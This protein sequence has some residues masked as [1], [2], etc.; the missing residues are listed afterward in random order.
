MVRLTVALR[1]Q[2]K[3]A[4]SEIPINEEILNIF[5]REQLSEH[6]L[7]DINPEGQV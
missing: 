7:C 6:F 3:N 5:N 1:G 2:A 4:E